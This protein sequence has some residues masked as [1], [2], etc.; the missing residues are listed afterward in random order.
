MDLEC[1][2]EGKADYIISY[3]F[4]RNPPFILE[5]VC[6]FFFGMWIRLS[7]NFVE[8]LRQNHSV[9]WPLISNLFSHG[10][11]YRL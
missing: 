1:A 9:V 11:L 7:L 3:Y 8:F 6:E 2:V 10:V 4:W 5:D